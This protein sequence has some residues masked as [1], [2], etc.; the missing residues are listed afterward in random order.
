MKK[1]IA[2]FVLFILSFLPAMV[3]AEKIVFATA[4][5]SPYIISE[6]G[7]VTGIDID[8][9][10][11]ICKRL[12]F[13]PEIQV[14]PWAR[15]LSYAENG[16]CDAIFTPRRNEEREKFLYYSSEPL[17]I[18][19]TVILALKGTGLKINKLKELKDKTVG[20]VRGYTYG[21]EFDNYNDV[22]KVV[23][24][25]DEQEVT[26]LAKERIPLIAGA[27]EGSIRYL[28]KK[29]GVESESVYVLGEEPAYIGF[30]KKLGEK[31]KTLADKFGEVLRKLKEEGF[32]KNLES[33]YF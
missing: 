2:A 1:L 21:K 14:L 12:G 26:I 9:V 15:A 3:Q 18:E 19:R 5:Q 17:R 27:E 22:K 7:Q 24:D 23:C 20:V 31:G 32:M 11:E 16:T 13:E 30:S 6:N 29:A 8:V 25:D 10:C 4:T 33:R 28:C